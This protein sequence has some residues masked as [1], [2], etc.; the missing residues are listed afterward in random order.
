[1]TADIHE[2]LGIVVISYQNGP[3]VAHKFDRSVFKRV[4]SLMKVHQV[5]LAGYHLCVDDVRFR[6]LWGLVNVYLDKEVRLPAR[7][8]EGSHT[9]CRTGLMS[10]G[11]PVD[12]LPINAEGLEENTYL[13]EWIQ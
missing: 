6:I 1:M 13:E 10:F 9:E 2:R 3:F 7:D 12:S 11:I 4:L 8:H 5:K